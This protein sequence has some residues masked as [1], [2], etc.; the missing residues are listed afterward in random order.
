MSIDCSSP[1]SLPLSL[2]PSCLN[3]EEDRETTNTIAMIKSKEFSQLTSTDI[4]I[5]VEHIG[6]AYTTYKD[7]IITNDID[8]A[9]L[10][11]C[12]DA[13]LNEILD[14]IGVTKK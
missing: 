5:Y 14:E 9:F 11:E 8:G 1:Q 4:A 7:M 3:E 13:L 6:T 12:D 2:P 10:T